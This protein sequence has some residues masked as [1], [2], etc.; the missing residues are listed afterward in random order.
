MTTF[1]SAADRITALLDDTRHVL[2]LT[3]VDPDGDALG[4]LTAVGQAM[5]ELGKKAT[6]A[7]DGGLLTRFSYLPLAD[8]VQ[9]GPPPHNQYDLIIAVDCGDEERM[10]HAFADLPE[11]RPP[12][13][14]IDHHITNTDFGVVNVVDASATSATEILAQLLP[15]LGVELSADI[16]LSLLTGLVT[17]TQGFSTLNVTPR[18]F[19]I[20]SSLM[21]A[22][23]DLPTVTMQALNLK[24]LATLKMWR[25]GLNNLKMKN[26]L[27]WTTI[28][29]A[30]RDAIGYRGV[31]SSGLVSMM[32]Y[33]DTAAISAVLT[34]LND[35][36][37]TV[38]FR[39]R[40][41]YNVSDLA[42]DLGG[43]GHPLAAGCA[44]DGPLEKAESLVLDLTH[45][46]I[47]ATNET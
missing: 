2:V 31:A 25:I 45:K 32:G 18:T 38:S 1:H 16:A 33:V 44:L 39:C 17:D 11:P 5:R 35:G 19:D 23:A 21:N 43:G 15:E 24:S 12:V 10:G 4:S 7:V 41:P 29:K 34:E 36:R 9:S 30:E 47:Q 3:H 27:I 20:A 8:E 46:A 42:R 40:P 13:V 6:M 26:G 22:G 37:V 28:S 14:N